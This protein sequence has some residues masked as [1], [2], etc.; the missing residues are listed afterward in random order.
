MKSPLDLKWL[1]AQINIESYSS[2][3]GE[4]VFALWACLL[5]FLL[6]VSSFWFVTVAERRFEHEGFNWQ[7][8]QIKVWCFERLLLKWKRSWL[9][10]SENNE[11]QG[12]HTNEACQCEDWTIPNS[13]SKPFLLQVSHIFDYLWVIVIQ[14][15]LASQY[16]TLLHAVP[17]LSRQ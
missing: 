11:K 12:K 1:S 2:C 14:G 13:L 17:Y 5:L 7:I 6:I 16:R 10:M 3:T 9:T 4:F 8:F 15:T